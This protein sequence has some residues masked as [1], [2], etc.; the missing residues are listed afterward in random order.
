MLLGKSSLS[1]GGGREM[2]RKDLSHLKQLRNDRVCRH[3]DSRGLVCRCDITVA[4]GE[5]DGSEVCAAVL[6]FFLLSDRFAS[7]TGLLAYNPTTRDW[8]TPGFYMTEA[9]NYQIDKN[10]AI[11]MRSTLRDSFMN[12]I[13][14]L[15]KTHTH[16]HNYSKS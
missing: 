4:A 2:G 16:A 3:G 8:S 13:F 5:D 1:G 11:R 7:E 10:V 15:L 9:Y 6:F 14:S 12:R